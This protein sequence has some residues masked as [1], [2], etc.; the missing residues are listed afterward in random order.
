M[1]ITLLKGRLEDG[2]YQ[3]NLLGIALISFAIQMSSHILN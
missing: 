3:A 2:L 1:G